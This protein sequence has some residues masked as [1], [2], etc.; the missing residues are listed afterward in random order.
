[1]NAEAVN[2]SLARLEKHA[3][4]D[5]NLMPAI[6]E[7]CENYVTLGEISDTLRKIFGTYKG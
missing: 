6:V 5:I 1:R 4:E 2:A 3:K 7:A